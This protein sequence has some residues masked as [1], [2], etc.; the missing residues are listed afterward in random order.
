MTMTTN[1]NNPLSTFAAATRAVLT[2]LSLLIGLASMTT[3]TAT[4]ETNES[5][6]PD[7]TQQ[8]SLVIYRGKGLSAN[9][10][11]YY[12]VYVDGKMLGQLKRNTA[13]QLNLSA[14]EHLIETNDPQESSL[15]VTVDKNSKSYVNAS[16]NKYWEVAMESVQPTAT[17]AARLDNCA[18]GV[19]RSC[20]LEESARFSSDRLVSR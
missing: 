3:M 1:T 8:G 6:Q 14:G 5:V 13:F 12:R 16:I 9:S 10:L 18:N 20:V 17:L 2:G 4:A 11:M 7:G 19:S 15:T